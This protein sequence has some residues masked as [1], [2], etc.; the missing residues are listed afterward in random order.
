MMA[1]IHDCAIQGKIVHTALPFAD[2]MR[3]ARAPYQAAAAELVL[4][5]K[6]AI[7]NSLRLPL[8]PQRWRQLGP[9]EAG[10]A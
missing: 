6:L 1:L 10:D 8:D 7:R 9:E 5:Y 4:H 2:L 3:R